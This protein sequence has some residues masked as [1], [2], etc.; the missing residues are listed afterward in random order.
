MPSR[1]SLHELVDRLP[2]AALETTERVLRNYQTWPPK[3]LVGVEKMRQRVDEMLRKRADEWAAHGRGGLIGSHFTGGHSKPDGD[4]MALGTT[5]D[6]PVLVN[7]EIRIFRGR[8]LELEERLRLSD[9]EKS[10]LYSKQIKGPDGKEGRYEIEF[11]A[12]EGLP[13]IS[14]D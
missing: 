10:L 9:D 5:M 4:G 6:G 7:F 12:S 1:E 2:E 8:R 14:E 3:P 11:D 13:P